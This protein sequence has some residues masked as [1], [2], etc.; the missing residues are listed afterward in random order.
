MAE[1]VFGPHSSPG[2]SPPNSDD[3]LAAT[4]RRERVD[5]L[6]AVLDRGARAVEQLPEPTWSALRVRLFA[7]LDGVRRRV[8]ALHNGPSQGSDQLFAVGLRV[9]ELTEECL[10]LSGGVRSRADPDEAQGC[11]LA[12]RLVASLVDR[13]PLPR[14]GSLTVPGPADSYHRRTRVLRVGLSLRLGADALWALPAV[15]HELGHQASPLVGREAGTQVLHE[16]Q[17]LLRR[18]GPQHARH[19][20]ELFADCFAAWMVGPA[21]GLYAAR[22]GFSPGAADDPAGSE[23]HPAPALRLRQVALT[24]SLLADTDLATKEI[25][26]LAAAGASPDDDGTGELQAWCD[27]LRDVLRTSL[28]GSAYAGW[29]DALGLAPALVAN[30]APPRVGR[31][32]SI[33]DVLNAA[34]WARTTHPQHLRRITSRSWHLLV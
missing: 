15:A 13:L 16:V 33:V 14:W 3:Q 29:R 9:R 26:R 2:G 24:T 32:P 20:S 28:G 17:E 19:L 25:E 10:E 27:R 22:L 1:L 7:E 6:Y 5:V 23:S 34:W 8:S 31:R 11:L 21:Y 12:D 30:A 18:A 4:L